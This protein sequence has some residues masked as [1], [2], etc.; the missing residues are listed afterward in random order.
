MCRIFLLV[1]FAFGSL[2]CSDAKNSNP[3]AGESKNGNS[4]V[5]ES[6][7]DTN[8]GSSKAD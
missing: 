8:Q 3:K 5:K 6:A 7:T 2:G 4:V 1:L